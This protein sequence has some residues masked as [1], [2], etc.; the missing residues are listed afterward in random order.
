M[1]AKPLVSGIIIFLNDERF[2][3]DAIESVFRQT[4]DNWELLLVDD[5]SWDGSSAIARGYAEEYP[6][7][8]RY[9]QHEGHANR[10]TSTSRNLGIRSGKGEYMAF[11][12][13]DDVWLPRKLEE[14]VFI[15]ESQPSTGM[16]YGAIQYWHSWSGADFPKDHVPSLG[17]AAN[18]L[19]LPPR[20]LTLYLQGKTRTASASDILVRR[21]T[22]ERV[23][24]FEEDFRGAY[25]DQAF[26]AKVCLKAPVLVAGEC[27]HRYRQHPG[28]CMAGM[29]KARTKHAL[30][31]GYLGWLEKYLVEQD[32]EDA[33]LWAALRKKQWRY[34]HPKLNRLVGRIRHPVRSTVNS[35]KATA[36]R[37]L[38]ALGGRPRKRYRRDG[39]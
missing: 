16:V 14:Q 18:T 30:G 39:N 38:P 4:Y 22:I 17:I 21:S 31:L 26:L 19:V 27:W 9:L 28:S 6:G 34:R 23:G 32:I 1:T 24:G 7:R 37:A 25:D 3:R 36:R 13:S 29:R 11:L 2:I 5:G 12:D 33:E 10:G 35:L 20:L 15:L 8:V